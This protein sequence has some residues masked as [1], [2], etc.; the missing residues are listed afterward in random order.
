MVTATPEPKA[1][2]GSLGVGDVNIASARA[3]RKTPPNPNAGLDQFVATGADG[4]RTFDSQAWQ[5]A[6]L[7]NKAWNAAAWSDVAWSDAAWSTVAWSDAAWADVAWASV[8]YGTVAWSDVAWSDAAWAD[9]AWA[10]NATDPAV[11]DAADATTAEQDAALAELGIVERHCDP[12]ISVCQARSGGA[13]QRSGH[14]GHERPP[15]VTPSRSTLKCKRAPET[16]PASRL[17]HER[18]NPPNG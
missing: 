1:A 14:N 6:A 8:A 15:A 2:K 12:T 10:D 11:G 3:Y 16:G 13:P 18:P 17:G 5:T 7:A 9:A 4:T